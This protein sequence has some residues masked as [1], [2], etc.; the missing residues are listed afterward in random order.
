LRDRYALERE[1]GRGG[2][3]EIPLV[4]AGLTH[5]HILPLH[6]FELQDEMSHTTAGSLAW[7]RELCEKVGAASG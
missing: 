3:Q 4:A 5:P 2:M 1:L 7:Y 6:V